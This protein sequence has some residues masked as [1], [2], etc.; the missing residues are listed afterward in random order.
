M[1][2]TSKITGITMTIAAAM[3]TA[4]CSEKSG[5]ESARDAKSEEIKPVEQAVATGEKRPGDSEVEPRSKSL[6][7]LAEGEAEREQHP[8]EDEIAEDC[9]AFVRATTTGVAHGASA[10]CP[11]CPGGTG[12]ME[13]LKFEDIKVDRMTPSPSGCEIDVALHARFNPSKGGPIAGG[14]T[15][16]I[17][18][19]QKA[20]YLRGETPPG[21]QTYH[22]KVIYRREGN[23]WRAVE[24]DR[25]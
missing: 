21:Q 9:V 4:S 14:L 17:T 7:E 22:V 19:D 18:P 15:G 3:I 13:V 20:R 23:R 6:A 24:F 2:H 5:V 1:F 16:W 11:Q 25:S 12:A 8:A 10:D